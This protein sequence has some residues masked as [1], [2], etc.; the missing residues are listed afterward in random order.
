MVWGGMCRPL[1]EH[2]FY[3]WPIKKS[4][5]D[6]YLDQVYRFLNIQKPIKK[7]LKLDEYINQI[8]FQWSEPTLR[9]NEVYK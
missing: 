7:D 9:I 2:D 8:D 1:D 3:K 4:D 5:L 6:P